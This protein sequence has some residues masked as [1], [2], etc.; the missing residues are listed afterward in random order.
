MVTTP[1]SPPGSLQEAEISRTAP[2]SSMLLEEQTLF[3]G[4]IYAD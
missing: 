4:F 2:F 3:P 1:V